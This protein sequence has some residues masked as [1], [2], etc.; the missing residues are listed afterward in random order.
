MTR[1]MNTSEETVNNL[2]NVLRILGF[3]DTYD[4]FSR[5]IFYW[6]LN[7]YWEKR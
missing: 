6:Q 3:L 1:M 7:N 2:A 5:V 4:P